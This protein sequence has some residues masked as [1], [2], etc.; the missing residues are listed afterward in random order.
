MCF[1]KGLLVQSVPALFHG[2]KRGSTFA[3]GTLKMRE[4]SV[5]TKDIFAKV[6]EIPLILRAYLRCIGRISGSISPQCGT[7]TEALK[8]TSSTVLESWPGIQP[9]YLRGFR[10]MRLREK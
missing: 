3:E 2:P 7:F 5:N 1:I 10:A 6:N 8:V 4:I 9:W